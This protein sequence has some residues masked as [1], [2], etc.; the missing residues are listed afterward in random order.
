LDLLIGL[1]WFTSLAFIYFGINCF[2]SKF[3]ISEFSRY[4]LPSYRKLI[5]GLQL[6]GAVGLLIG[7]YFSPL[8]LMFASIGLCLLMTSGFIVRI[9]IKDNFIKSSPA[10]TFAAINLGIAIKA[11][12]T[13][14]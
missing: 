7:L 1:T 11:F 12:Y 9:K 5:G 14:F 10:F 2:Y 3:I 13:Y 6:L 8:L 4:T